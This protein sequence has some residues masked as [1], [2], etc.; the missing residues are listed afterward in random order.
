MLPGLPE[1][2][3]E[4]NL[5]FCSTPVGDPRRNITQP[6]AQFPDQPI[7]VVGPRAAEFGPVLGEHAAYLVDPLEVTVAEAAQPVT[8]LRFELE[9]V[10]PPRL[11]AYGWSDYRPAAGVRSYAGSRRVGS[12]RPTAAAAAPGPLEAGSSAHDQVSASHAFEH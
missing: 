3:Q 5:P 9:V 2:G 7:Q 1:R 8:D 4:H 10:Q 11:I 6:D 12:R